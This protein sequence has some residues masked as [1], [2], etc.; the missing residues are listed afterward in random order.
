MSEIQYKKTNNIHS[1]I[2]VCRN[3]IMIRPIKFSVCSNFF[4]GFRSLSCQEDN[5]INKKTICQ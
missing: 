4:I 1:W 3:V 5:L 2:G